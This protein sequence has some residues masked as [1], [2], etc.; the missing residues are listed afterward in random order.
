VGGRALLGRSF[1][2]GVDDAGQVGIHQ[3]VPVDIGPL[4]LHWVYRTTAYTIDDVPT[5][6]RDEVEAGLTARDAADA[7]RIIANF[8]ELRDED[9]TTGAN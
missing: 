3:G 1:Y 7:E 5:I 4:P 8:D 2:V 9:D 6:V